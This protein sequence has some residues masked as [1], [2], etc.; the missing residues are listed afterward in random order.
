MPADR[1]WYRNLVISHVIIQTLEGLHMRY[2]APETG[3]DDIVIE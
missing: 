3:L 1:K 2:P